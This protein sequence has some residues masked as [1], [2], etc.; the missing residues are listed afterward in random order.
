[1]TPE[2]FWAL[3]DTSSR[4]GGCWK[5]CGGLNSTLYGYTSLGSRAAHRTAFDL[6]YGATPIP[7]FKIMH[8]CDHNQCVN[9]EHLRG[10]SDSDNSRMAATVWRARRRVEGYTSI[11][12]PCYGLEEPYDWV[13]EVRQETWPG[14]RQTY[15]ILYRNQFLCA[16]WGE[17]GR[18][19]NPT[20]GVI[21]RNATCSNCL[22]ALHKTDM[23]AY[24]LTRS[25]TFIS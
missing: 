13:K 14:A 2:Q 18:E 24:Y 7:G 6:H 22:L 15:H 4:N 25:S 16:N 3:A 10:G 19:D 23:H 17:Y 11:E 21:H 8:L 5:W 20:Y 12:M 1:M 9:P